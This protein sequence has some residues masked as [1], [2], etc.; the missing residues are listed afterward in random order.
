MNKKGFTVVELIVSFALV[1]IVVVIL[2]QIVTIVKTLYLNTGIKT[3]LLH[4]QAIMNRKISQRFNQKDI[5]AA[6][7]CGAGCLTFIYEDD[8]SSN[9]LINKETGSFSFIDNDN[10]TINYSTKLL[11]GSTFGDI[12]ISNETIV[13]VSDG[14]D[15]SLLKIKV[16]VKHTLVE[17]DFGINL[18]YQYDS[19]ITAIA[20]IVF[21]DQATNEGGT[22]ILKGSSDLTWNKNLPFTDPGYYVIDE[23]GNICTP[24]A[25]ESCGVVVTGTVGNEVNQTY[26]LTYTFSKDGRELDQKV[27]RVLIIDDSYV[28]DYTGDLQMFT[29]PQDG[30]YKVELWGAQGGTI[31]SSYPGGNGSYTVG[32]ISLTKNEK[33]FVYVGEQPKSNTGG[34]NGGGNADVGF[35]GGGG[36]T[37]VRL[38]SGNWKDTTSLRSRIMVAA[39]GSGGYY[40]TKYPYA[41]SPGGTINGISKAATSTCQPLG[42]TQT[43]GGTCDDHSEVSGGFGFGGNGD[44]GGGSG[45]YGGAGRYSTTISGAVGG[46]GSSF[47]SGYEGC[48]AVTESGTASGTP[49][50]YSGKVF[51]NSQMIAGNSGMPNP[52]GSGIIT[53]NSGNGYARITLISVTS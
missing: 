34:Y 16:P 49:T 13:G 30:V 4:K 6:V 20:D 48:N 3:E 17:G 39:A 31:N 24:S 14:K 25:G 29:A 5:K 18:V 23:R 33:L 28:Y 53:G 27:R 12:D 11:T 7:R 42:G 46:S 52:R 19:R 21:D 50:H 37:D 40:Y 47:I 38:T 26:N 51:T 1:M 8:T 15:N 36:S 45:Y 10:G 44:T 32:E 35:A 2:V 22:I 41:G 9:L 43:A